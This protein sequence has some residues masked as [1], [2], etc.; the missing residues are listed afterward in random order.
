MKINKER[1][2]WCCRLKPKA[3]WNKR[4]TNEESLVCGEPVILKALHGCCWRTSRWP[5]S[6]KSER[7]NRRLVNKRPII[8]EL[9]TLGHILVTVHHSFPKIRLEIRREVTRQI[10]K[11]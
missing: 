4:I 11:T 9:G 3:R 5:L 6:L 10:P 7:G 1:E 2:T 8:L